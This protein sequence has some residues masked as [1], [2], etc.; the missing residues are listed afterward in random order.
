MASSSGIGQEFGLSE[1]FKEPYIPIVF[2]LAVMI[3]VRIIV[4]KV[5]KPSVPFSPN[6]EIS[7]K[8]VLTG[9]YIYPIKSCKGI[10]LQKAKVGPYGLENDRRWMVYNTETN[11]FCTQRTMPKMAL[12]A[13]TF[14]GENMC[15]NFPEMPT[16]KVPISGKRQKQE[17]IVSDIGIWKDNV[18]GVDEGDDVA[19]WIS[20]CLN[21]PTLRLIRLCDDHDRSIPSNWMHKDME[22]DRQLVSFADGFPFLLASEESLEDLNKKLPSGVNKLPMLRFRPNFVVKG[23]DAGFEEDLWTKIKMGSTVFRV[24]KKC[25]RC[26]LTTVD[27]SKGAFAGD[28]PLNTLKTY[29]KGL[30]EGKDEVCF[31][32][33]LVHEDIGGQVTVGMPVEILELQQEQVPATTKLS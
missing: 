31:A 11:R 9:I 29:R 23:L 14:E 33:N 8:V 6:S 15:L 4:R 24:T 18:R 10:A 7:S 17:P 19:A 3:G 5:L 26:K 2:A 30:L 25:T 22:A 20:N 32:Q 28:E 27:P 21:T 12:I 13:P 1:L 16:M